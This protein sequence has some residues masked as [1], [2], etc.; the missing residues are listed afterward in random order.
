MNWQVKTSHIN[1]F[2][3]D[4]DYINALVSQAN[5]ISVKN[6]DHWVFSYHGLP[7]RQLKKDN[8]S[9]L[10]GNCCDS[11]NESNKNCYRGSIRPTY[12]RW[13]QNPLRPR[14]VTAIRSCAPR[15]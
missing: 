1:S 2:E 12:R 15:G 3:T 5:S 4:D 9:C 11:L 13:R 10:I 8:S 14:A 6:I 7:E